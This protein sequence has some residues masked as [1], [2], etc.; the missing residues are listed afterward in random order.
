MTQA[1]PDKT[2]KQGRF[3]FQAYKNKCPIND[4]CSVSPMD[5]TVNSFAKISTPTSKREDNP[6]LYTLPPEW[7]VGFHFADAFNTHHFILALDQ[8]FQTTGKWVK[9]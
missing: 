3:L 7:Q 6:P 5:D 9:P 1:Q 8:V 4:E 2:H